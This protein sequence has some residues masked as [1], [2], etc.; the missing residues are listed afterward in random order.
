MSL[1]FQNLLV[2]V[3]RPSFLML[4]T[5]LPRSIVVDIYRSSRTMFMS[6]QNA[7]S[8]PLHAHYTNITNC[9]SKSPSPAPLECLVLFQRCGHIVAVTGDGVNDSPALK[10]AD[11]GIAMG[12]MGSAV[13]KQA[14]D[15]I[16]LDDNFASIVSGV[17]EGR[18][19]FDN[20]KKSIAYT[21]TSNIPGECS[22]IVVSVHVEISLPFSFMESYE[23]RLVG[24]LFAMYKAASPMFPSRR[25]FCLFIECTLP[26]NFYF[27]PSPPLLAGT[28]AK[29][30]RSTPVGTCRSGTCHTRACSKFLYSS[31]SVVACRCNDAGL[32]VFT[33]PSSLLYFSGQKSRPSSA[34]S[35]WALRSLCRL[36]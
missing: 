10:K 32:F 15:M 7:A 2:H 13:S 35:R 36:C 11:I 19:I 5:L 12:I 26:P 24:G 17:E 21:L 25:L 14:A 16:L 28:E 31:H 1:F 22:Y 4:D 3:F 20:L 33:F 34:S 6:V 8:R 18:L 23:H 27:T 30:K 29:Y 9:W